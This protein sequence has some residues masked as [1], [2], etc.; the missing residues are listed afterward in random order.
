MFKIGDIA[1]ANSS[2]KSYYSMITIKNNCVVEI[3]DIVDDLRVCAKIIFSTNVSHIGCTRVVWTS[4]LSKINKRSIK[5][6]PFL[7]RFA[8]NKEDIFVQE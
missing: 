1:Y 3:I 8:L 7:A 6:N 5:H 2:T 4:L